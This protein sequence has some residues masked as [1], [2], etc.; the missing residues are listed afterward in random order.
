MHTRT[1]EV[2]ALVNQWKELSELVCDPKAD[3]LG[4]HIIDICGHGLL[5]MLAFPN[6]WQREGDWLHIFLTV[7]LRL[8]LAKQD[9]ILVKDPVPI[10]KALCQVIFK[11]PNAELENGMKQ[12]I[13][14]HIVH[15][16]QVCEFN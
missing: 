11:T 8:Q 3:K 15:K 14:T 16:E 2:D 12:L 10:F 6:I 1:E 5:E 7:D 9:R 13:C 4:M